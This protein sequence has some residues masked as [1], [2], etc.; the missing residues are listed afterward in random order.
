M[1]Y[2]FLIG[3]VFCIIPF[4]QTC[5]RHELTITNSLFQQANK[6]N[7]TWKHP[8]SKNWHTLDYIVVRQRDVKEVHITRAMRGSSCWS[9]HRL[10]RM[11]IVLDLCTPRRHRSIKRKRLNI[12]NTKRLQVQSTTIQDL[13]DSR[14]SEPKDDDE[15]TSAS[16][17]WTLLKTRIQ[18][19]AN[20]VLGF[21]TKKHQD[22]FD[23]HD[24]E[25]R[26]LLDTMHCT[27][28]A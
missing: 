10:L 27:H 22:W 28:L 9:D 5:A 24:L 21:Q 11:S 16:E 8:R 20:E 7:T 13:L 6:Y 19:T 15:Q 23:E 3:H 25:A 4:L 12:S 14:L 18:Q 1:F 26:N 17:D 2:C